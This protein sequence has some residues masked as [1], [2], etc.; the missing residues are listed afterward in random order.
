MT[1]PTLTA[2]R[3]S[4]SGKHARS[5]LRHHRVPAVLYGHDV[6]NVNLEVDQPQFQK[7]WRQAGSSSLIDLVI[8]QQPAVKVLIHAVQ[9]HP[10][11]PEV[12]HVDFYQVKMSEKLQAEVGLNFIGESPAVK[13]LGGI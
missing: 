7:I 13:E 3:R 9:R 5:L 12:T 11:R 6:T 4:A 10:L 2:S 1:A 8:D